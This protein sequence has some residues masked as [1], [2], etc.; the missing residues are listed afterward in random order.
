VIPPIV[1]LLD[2][3]LDRSI[4][5]VGTEPV[6]PGLAATITFIVD[7][8]VADL[9]AVDD[10]VAAARR[11]D[12]GLADER[13]ERQLVR[14]SADASLRCGRPFSVRISNVRRDW[15]NDSVPPGTGLAQP[16]EAVA[17]SLPAPDHRSA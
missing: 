7:A 6:A 4:A 9:A 1:A 8:V 13:A 15:R 2:P 11:A 17:H 5:A 3:R 16:E 12:G 10:A 14:R